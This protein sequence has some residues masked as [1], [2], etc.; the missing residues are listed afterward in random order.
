MKMTVN[1]NDKILVKMKKNFNSTVR[2]RQ[3]QKLKEIEEAHPSYRKI[4]LHLLTTAFAAE[5]EPKYVKH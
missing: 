1:I 4:I 2:D 3:T 5:A